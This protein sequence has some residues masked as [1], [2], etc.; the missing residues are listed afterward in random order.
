[1]FIWDGVSFTGETFGI[2]SWQKYGDFAEE[3]EMQ[4]TVTVTALAY[5]KKATVEYLTEIFHDWLLNGTDREVAIHPD[6]LRVSSV[7]SRS[8]DDSVIKATM[9]MN[10]SIAHDFEDPKNQLTHYLKVT[11]AGLLKSDAVTRLLNTGN[12]KDVTISSYPFWNRSVSG[13][14][15]NIEFVIKK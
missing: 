11:I 3:I 7:I 6:T 2:I 1:M 13:N 15:D 10:T 5:D 12:V 4:W 9:E 8:P 14:I